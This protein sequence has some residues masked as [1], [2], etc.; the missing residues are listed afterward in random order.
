MQWFHLG[1]RKS[2]TVDVVGRKGI[3]KNLEKICT[4]AA[5]LLVLW[6]CALVTGMLFGGFIHILLVIAIIIVLLGLISEPQ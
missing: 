2:E 4:T 6:V 1:P 3:M 5:I